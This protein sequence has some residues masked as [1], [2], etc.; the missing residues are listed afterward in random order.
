MRKVLGI[1]NFIDTSN[2][3]KSAG[4]SDATARLEQDNQKLFSLYT[5]VNNLAYLAKMSQRAGMTDGQL[6]GFDTR[7]QDGLAQVQNFIKTKSFNNFTLQMGK[8]NSSVTSSVSVPFAP[9]T[10]QGGTVVA[11]R[12]YR[13]RR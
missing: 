3:P 8:T 1:T 2:V 7:F 4:S 9:F 6:A 12:Q 10:Y 5:A 13:Q 11:R